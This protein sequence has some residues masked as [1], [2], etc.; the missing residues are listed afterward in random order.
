[1]YISV[2]HVS[3]YDRLAGIWTHDHWFNALANC[4]AVT[5]IQ[6]SAAYGQYFNI[7]GIVSRYREHVV[8]AGTRHQTLT[9]IHEKTKECQQ[10][11]NA[12]K[13]GTSYM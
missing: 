7:S 6:N 4:A 10:W 3:H 8:V 1:M 9:M 13:V 11:H 12:H 5:L 2:S